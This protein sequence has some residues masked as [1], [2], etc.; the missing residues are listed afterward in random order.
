MM[1]MMMMMMM[2]M[3]H[4]KKTAK[5]G[6]DRNGFNFKP[7]AGLNCNSRLE[8]RCAAPSA[9][10]ISGDIPVFAG[11]SQTYVPGSPSLLTHILQHVAILWPET[12][13]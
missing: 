10:V 6:I 7:T 12:L 1:T 5:Y 8:T 13:F 9:T 11:S 4:A 3:N 2:M